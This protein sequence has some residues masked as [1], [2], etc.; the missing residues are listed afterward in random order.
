M[1][2][3]PI[4]AAALK[5]RPCDGSV[6]KIGILENNTDFRLPTKNSDEAVFHDPNEQNSLKEHPGDFRAYPVVFMHL[7][8]PKAERYT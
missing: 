6:T 8:K 2:P 5:G 3:R 1:R 7:K 4:R